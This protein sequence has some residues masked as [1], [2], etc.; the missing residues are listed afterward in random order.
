V[1][2]Q[3]ASGILLH[4]T[5]LPSPHGIG[6]LG[7]SAYEFIDFLE[8]SGQKLWQV[9]PLGPTGDEHSPYI[10]NYS[11]FAG[12][13]LLL[14]LELL[15]A[16]QLLHPDELSPLADAPSDRVDFA[17]V[18]PH[19]TH[20]LKI[21]FNNFKQRGSNGEFEEFCQQTIWLDDFAL[22][23]ALLEA[24][25]G[26][27]WNV[28]EGA[29][30]RR[31]PAALAEQRE[32]LYDAILYQ[33]FL[34]FQ[35]FEQWTKLR[36]YANEKNIQI[37]GDVSIYVCHN[38]AEVWGNPEIFKLAPQTLEPAFMAGVPPDYFSAT[39][40]LW[41]NPVYNW[42][43][44]Q[45]TQFAW[46]IER[47][48]ATLQYVDIVR[49]DHFRGFEAYWQV[50]AGETT[51]MRGE[52]VK[53]PGFEFFE[54]LAAGLGSLPVMAEDLGIITPEVEELRDRFQFPGMRIL[55]F[56]FSGDPENS[57]LPHNYISNSVVYPGTHDN[58]TTIGWWTTAGATEKQQVAEYLGYDRPED[59]PEINWKMMRMALASVSDLA[60]LSLQDMF[61]LGSEG[62][63]NDPSINAGQW[64]W[65]YQSSEQLSHEL[66]DRL[67]WLT[68]L[69]RR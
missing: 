11:A 40:Q 10:M 29:I 50:P 36:S 13:P 5:C 52:W 44:L 19:K 65:R 38:S 69:Y 60:I 23:M 39:G 45:E 58:D 42:D 1:T 61:G 35:F 51:A 63:M 25:A 18:I 24:N 67:G 43:K 32:K 54:A 17:K 56:A 68:R 26:K 9:L 48:K 34:Q 14:S 55:Q 28:W 46:W 66:S 57:Y 37:V 27:A 31:D 12:N 47:F 62:R 20:Y 16:E 15:A 33:K 4:P 3:R 49:I 22:F 8:R 21:A 41:G 2:F 59:V 6:D 64:R 7:Q 53:A 30:A